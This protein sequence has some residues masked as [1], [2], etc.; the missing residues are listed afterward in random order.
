[1]SESKTPLCKIDWYNKDTVYQGIYRVLNTEN[2]L[3]DPCEIMIL[4]PLPI[5]KEAHERVYGLCWRDKK[6]IWFRIQPPNYIEFAHELLHLIE[7]KEVELEEV[8][9]YNLSHLVVMLAENNI[10]PPV[11]PVRLFT[12]A[13]VDMVL[14]ALRDVYGYPFKDIAEYF[15]IIGVIPPFLRLDFD[16]ARND[17]V[18]KYNPEY[19]EKFIAIMTITELIAGAE[20][21]RVM[22]D[23]VLKLLEKLAAK[24]GEPAVNT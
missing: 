20:Y 18:L 16:P 17:I 21:D 15:E 3:P 19:N 9:A 1:M 10:N 12:D 23:V 24:H 11:N 2:R 22:L 14:Q 8:Y 7:G 5:P 13:T 4:P 6:E